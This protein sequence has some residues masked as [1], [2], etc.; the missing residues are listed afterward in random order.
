[1]IVYAIYDDE[2]MGG[3]QQVFVKRGVT[4]SVFNRLRSTARVSTPSIAKDLRGRCA[5]GSAVFD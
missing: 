4:V 2:H 1:V 3:N 5:T